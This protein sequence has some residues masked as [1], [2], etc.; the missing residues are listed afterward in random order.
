MKSRQEKSTDL[1]IAIS[2]YNSESKYFEIQC[3]NCSTWYYEPN[4]KFKHPIVLC[5]CCGEYFGV[6][7]GN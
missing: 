6:D 4:R 2:I 7:Y 3:P 5:P 1:Q